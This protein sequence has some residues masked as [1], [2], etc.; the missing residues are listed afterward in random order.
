[1][2]PPPLQVPKQQETDPPNTAPQNLAGHQTAASPESDPFSDLSLPGAAPVRTE[3]SL[4]EIVDQIGSTHCLSYEV[5]KG[6]PDIGTIHVIQQIHNVA[7]LS[8]LKRQDVGRYQAEILRMLLREKP[9]VVFNESTVGVPVG[10]AANYFFGGDSLFLKELKQ[11]GELPGEFT[12]LQLSY[13][14][15]RGASLFYK[16]LNPDAEIMPVISEREYNRYRSEVKPD[17]ERHERDAIVMDRRERLAM[18][19]IERYF[20]EHPG[21]NVFLVYGAAHQWGPEDLRNPEATLEQRPQIETS[22]FPGLRELYSSDQEFFKEVSR[23][24]GLE[25]EF[26]ARLHEVD[27]GCLAAIGDSEAFT[28]A[29]SKANFNRGDSS[30][31]SYLLED[32]ERSPERQR[33]V[34]EH[35][36]HVPVRSLAH[37]TEAEDIEYSLRHLDP[38]AQPW[39]YL[40]A[41]KSIDDST[42]QLRLLRTAAIVHPLTQFYARSDEAEAICVSRAYE[43]SPDDLEKAIS[44]RSPEKVREMLLNANKISPRTFEEIPTAELQSEAFGKISLEMSGRERQYFGRDYFLAHAKSEAVRDVIEESRL[45]SEISDTATRFDCV[46]ATELISELSLFAAFPEKQREIIA[47]QDT[48]PLLALEQIQD[49]ELLSAAVE[50]LKEPTVRERTGFNL[51]LAMLRNRNLKAHL[52]ELLPIANLDAISASHVVSIL[53]DSPKERLEILRSV[54]EFPVG[55]FHVLK[56]EEEQLAA[57][58]VLTDPRNPGELRN[59]RSS[60]VS[61]SVLAALA[62]R[63]RPPS[64][65]GGL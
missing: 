43:L 32:L 39:D 45:L 60:A 28:L 38:F 35:L 33:I 25:R 26:V 51:G 16:G 15:D 34:I 4:R 27:I 23:Y 42:L 53:Y 2:S 56:T 62:E 13:L 41:S 5:M 47:A 12:P 8:D 6:N 19:E 10:D 9:P 29:C 1:M 24:P 7:E 54:R 48:V 40:L 21:A 18:A 3:S 36:D 64:T 20:D 11:S 44:E 61:D 65:D 58:P 30:A 57:V 59:A 63:F 46:T 49:R 17:M 22:V 31:V 14:T 50:K 52:S 37:M 55:A